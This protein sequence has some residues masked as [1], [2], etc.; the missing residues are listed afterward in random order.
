[1]V[2]LLEAIQKFEPDRGIVFEAYARIRIRGAVLDALRR[3]DHLSRRMRRQSKSLRDTHQKMEQEAGAPV[4]D[5]E[6]AES[7]G[8]SIKEV[9]DSRIRRA[10]PESVDPQVLDSIK[11]NA[12]WQGMPT[13]LES[14]EREEAITMVANAL[15]ELPER[16][17]LIMGLYYEAEL[18]L[19]EIGQVVGVTESRVSQ[20]MRKTVSMIRAKIN[21]NES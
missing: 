16:N 15:A 14:L 8:L 10:A 4:G 21:V 1:M 12:L 18:T 9:Q 20:I 5:A 19:K 7:T 17:R 6:V 3:L 11:A 2:G 13:V